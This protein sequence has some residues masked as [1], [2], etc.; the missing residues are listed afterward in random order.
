[1]SDSDLAQALRDDVRLLGD[2]LGETLSAQEGP[3]L[4]E[5][6]E[7]IRQLAKD[8]RAG[9]KNSTQHLVDKLASLQ[10]DQLILVARAFS[11]FLNLSN[12]AEQYH[13][14]RS[15]RDNQ[16]LNKQ[17][18][19]SLHELIPRLQKK[20]LSNQDI[21]ENIQSLSIEL[22]LTAH[23]TEV[24]RRTFI[25][26]YDEINDSL[27]ALD[28]L[29]LSPYERSLEVQRLRREI[30]AAWR[31]DEIRRDRPTPIDEARWGFV[32]IE[33][34]LWH[35]VPDYLRELD[36]VLVQNGLTPLPIDNVPIRFASWM[37]GDRDGNP[38]VTAKVTERVVLL[39]RWMAM[40]LYLRDVAE[41]HAELSMNQCS[42]NFR[43]L[44]GGDEGSEPYREMLKRL[45]QKL[46]DQRAWLEA[47]LDGELVADAQPITDLNDLISPLMACYDSLK[48]CGMVVV[49][50]GCL[51]DTL[52]RLH[53]FGLNLVKLDVRQESTRHADVINAI[54][55]YLGLGC[56]NDWSEAEKQKFLLTE[57]QN[58]RPLIPK[59]LP[60]TPEIQEVLDTFN[61][62]AKQPF[63]SLGAYVISMATYPSDV[64]AVQLLQKEAGMQRFMR[65]VPLFETLDDL[66][67]APD[68]LAQLLGIEF[69][70]EIIQGKQEV[71]IGYS[72]SAKDA[73][74]LAASWQQYQ[75]QEQLLGIS[76]QH[77]V[78]LTLF[79]GRG[80]SASRG[81]APFHEA[82]L[83]QPPGTVNGSLRVT[84][85]GEMIRY[86]F[87]PLG[88]AM[89]TLEMYVA[90]TLEA[91]MAPHDPPKP[92]W[93]E[94]MAYLA[95]KALQAYRGVVREDPRF[96]PYFR[97]ATPEQ[98]LQRLP[99]GSRPAKRKPTGGVESLRAI[100]WVFAWTQMRLLLT[101]WLG[102]D[103]AL[104]SA[105]GDGKMDML[106]EMEQHWPYFKMVIGML[107][108]V[109][110][111]TD[112]TIAQYYEQRLA[113]SEYRSL[114]G[115][116]RSRLT[117]TVDLTKTLT[118]HSTLLQNNRS[119]QRSIQVRNPYLDPLHVLQVELMR[120]TRVAE[121]KGETPPDPK[122]L[123]ITVAG[124]AAGMRNTG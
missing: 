77:D 37:G 21:Q 61:T 48:E 123:M 122:A 24:T 69:Y 97:E 39:A 20:G 2:L 57:L 81:G 42:D 107:E 72:D 118:G 68:T 15:R 121:V 25:R 8:T 43:E 124:I 13:T 110:A 18:Q 74:F 66:K 54:C 41:L 45:R 65:V 94:M 51:R 96:I 31:T 40:D 111:K 117:E 78:H 106:Q 115:E 100:P 4:L 12:I 44:I 108:M 95:E 104:K 38:N 62:I 109:L 60:T 101:A 28:R 64:L 116:L 75:A 6:V 93:R 17:L 46:E 32:T 73:G 16:Q 33:Q 50:N 92:E 71:M 1:M 9:K 49:A 36:E 11:Q 103:A 63:A 80:G 70:R 27:E 82:I 67:G 53:C 3:W 114:G 91:T 88:V 112:P 99:L 10:D 29:A 85:Q 7:E 30:A 52:R 120:R 5:L 98:E 113:S 59:E 55:E 76:R 84:E 119:T 22:V 102:T 19:G 90:A 87:S 56:Y 105:F 35:A 83:S 34:T 26:K 14:V 23:P 86:K 47:K 89:K 79:H 58:K